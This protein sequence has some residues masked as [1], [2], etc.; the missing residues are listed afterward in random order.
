MAQQLEN[1]II[2]ETYYKLNKDIQYICTIF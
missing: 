2:F 1:G